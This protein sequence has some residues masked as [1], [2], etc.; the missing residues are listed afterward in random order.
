MWR[1]P[2]RCSINGLDGKCTTS[3][4]HT[5]ACDAYHRVDMYINI[6][7]DVYIV[8][9]LFIVFQIHNIGIFL[10]M[11]EMGGIEAVEC[12]RKLPSISQPYVQLTVACHKVKYTLYI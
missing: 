6:L 1:K 4:T 12:I 2:I 9:L 10:Q 7:Y 3:H 5:Y 8:S 11:P